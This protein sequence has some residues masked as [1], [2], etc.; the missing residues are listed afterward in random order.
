MIL[1][2]IFIW[3][4]IGRLVKRE[5]KTKDIGKMACLFIVLIPPV[6]GM[7]EFAWGVDAISTVAFY[8]PFKEM[9]VDGVYVE[10]ISETV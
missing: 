5:I 2:I 7:F 4:G 3:W 9:L 1:F 6:F 8:L 10:S